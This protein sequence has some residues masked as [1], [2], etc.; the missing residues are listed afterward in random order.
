MR[1]STDSGMFAGN[2]VSAWDG[3]QESAGRGRLFG[4]GPGTGEAVG[5]GAGLDDGAVES[6]AVDDGRAEAWIRERLGPASKGLVGGDGDAVLLL[7][8]GQDLEEEFSAVGSS[9]M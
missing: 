1:M 4:S 8:F 6:E 5:V 7:A 9:S 2:D 3:P